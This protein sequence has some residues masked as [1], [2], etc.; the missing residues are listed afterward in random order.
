MAQKIGKNRYLKNARIYDT[1]FRAILKEF[2]LDSTAHTTALRVGVNRRTVN[3]IFNLIRKRLIVL[4]EKDSKFS[5]EVEI[6]ESY[7]GP[8]RVRGKR[9]RGAS[10]KIPVIGL[11]KRNGTVYSKPIKNATRAQLMPVIRGK[12]LEG[13]T[14]HT[15][16]WTSYDALILNGYKHKRVFHSRDE[17]VRGKSHVNG[18]ESFWSFTKR[19][20]AK[21]NGVKKKYF[22]LHLKESEYR[23]NNRNKKDM[24][25]KLLRE[26]RKK[27]L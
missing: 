3:R 1:Q 20:L 12:V 26:F 13:S 23:W 24:Y 7:F 17:F 14:I 6:D 22:L 19:R 10:G 21:F 8:R 4:C 15:D 16:G 11:L 2:C 27:P 5:G 25:E 18:I 9:G